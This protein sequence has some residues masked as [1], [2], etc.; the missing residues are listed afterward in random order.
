VG[1][2]QGGRRAGA[3][4]RDPP[5]TRA[6]SVFFAACRGRNP[7]FSLEEKK[8]GLPPFHWGSVFFL[9]PIRAI[10]WF[11]TRPAG[12]LPGVPKNPRGGIFQDHIFRGGAGPGPPVGGGLGPGDHR[13]K[14]TLGPPG[15]AERGGGM[16]CRFRVEKKKPRELPPVGA[17]P[18]PPSG[19]DREAIFFFPFCEWKAE[20]PGE[21]GEGRRGPNMGGPGSRGRAKTL[22]LGRPAEFPPW[23]PKTQ[24]PQGKKKGGPFVPRGDPHGKKSRRPRRVRAGDGLTEGGP[25]ALRAGE[26]GESCDPQNGEAG[27]ET[28]LVFGGGK[29]NKNIFPRPERG[30]APYPAR[31]GG[32]TRGPPHPRRF[33]FFVFVT[34]AGRPPFWPPR[35]QF[36]FV[37]ASTGKKNK[38]G[39]G[40]PPG[41]DP[42]P[43]RGPPPLGKTKKTKARSGC[44]GTRR[45][46]PF[47]WEGGRRHG[48]RF[49][50]FGLFFC[51]RAF[52]FGVLPPGLAGKTKGG[53]GGRDGS[54][55]FHARAPANGPP[56]VTG[57]GGGNTNFLRAICE[58][59]KGVGDGGP[60]L[61][62]FSPIGGGAGK[63]KNTRGFR[64]A[65]AGA[66]WGPTGTG[67]KNR[68]PG[69]TE[70]L[71]CG[72]NP[73]VFFF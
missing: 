30:T 34:Q 60:R 43:G 3:R 11:F 42:P 14:K 63:K 47:F 54:F 24:L 53:G 72:G 44:R 45:G 48:G 57:H 69:L 21:Q 65:A 40:R 38:G 1:D 26:G 20:F 22:I 2:S 61:P 19:P 56:Y 6:P 27:G 64:G 28:A 62:F 10:A 51:P 66:P 39:L 52:F 59:G 29:Q 17:G 73:H 31:G 32:G 7:I 12:A 15:P 18:G 37:G 46:R 9:A 5:T 25:R 71:S 67:A 4:F 58:H 35:A 16:P 41:P 33:Y 8:R 13:K 49:R 70:P 68:G 50:G 55:G 36:G 23:R